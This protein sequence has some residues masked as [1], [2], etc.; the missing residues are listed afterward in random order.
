MPN[1]LGADPASDRRDFAR[2]FADPAVG[3]DELKVYPCSLLES[4][5]LVRFARS[6]AWRPYDHETLVALLADCLAQVPRWCR[7][8]R[9]IRDIPSPEILV[10]NRQTNLREPVEARLRAQGRTLVEMRAR[11]IRSTPLDPR[12]LR[13]RETARPVAGG[14]ERFLEWVTGADRLAAF[15]RVFLP[16]GP[17][18]GPP[19]EDA[20]TAPAEL[21]G[22]AVLREV[23]VYGT[24]AALGERAVGKAQHTGLGRRLVAAAAERARAHGCARL[25]VIS[26][27]GT[28]GWYRRL[29][30]GDGALYQQLP[31]DVA[32][33]PGPAGRTGP[34]EAPL[35][36]V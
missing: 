10:G 1:L 15:A 36:R 26:A 32:L 3:P 23:H 25:A 29:G 14:E 18:A 5:E 7:V 24:A 33:R 4:A 28:R 34:A 22:C 6:G 30:F 17:A 11:E 31:L 19:V 27:V 2:L 9:V 16:G 8:T 13:L 20:P 12:E 21:S 35:P